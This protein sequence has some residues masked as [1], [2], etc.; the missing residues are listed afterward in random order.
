M[1]IVKTKGSAEG[2]QADAKP[3]S[4][5]QRPAAMVQESAPDPLS[6]GEGFDDL[7]F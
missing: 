4:Q 6:Q 3:V 5:P 7:P 2:G 1:N